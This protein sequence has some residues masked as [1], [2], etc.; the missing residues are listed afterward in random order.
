MTRRFV[1]LFLIASLLF[2][3]LTPVHAQALP[4]RVAIAVG[5]VIER[6]L[7]R[8][9]FAANDPRIAKTL[10][11]VG[12]AANDSIF[13]VTSGVGMAVAGVAGAAATAGAAVSGTGNTKAP[14]SAQ[15]GVV[16]AGLALVAVLR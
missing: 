7:S 14:G 6:N 12:V 5:G 8:L 2:S 9:G 1:S 15:G 13:T 4:S 16:A 10:S 11:A 3:S